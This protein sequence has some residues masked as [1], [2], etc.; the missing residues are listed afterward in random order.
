MNRK[1][2]IREYIMLLQKNNKEVEP[3]YKLLGDSLTIYDTLYNT[4]RYIAK[5]LHISTEG[6]YSD[7]EFI[8]DYANCG[9]INYNG[10]RIE[11]IDRFLEIFLESEAAYEDNI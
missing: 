6:E 4:E 9:Y 1:E 5:L 7:F 3:Y 2:M 10:E 11:D 8:Y